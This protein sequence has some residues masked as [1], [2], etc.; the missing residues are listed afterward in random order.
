MVS[1]TLYLAPQTGHHEPPS[2]GQ[3]SQESHHITGSAIT[4]LDQQPPATGDGPEE[5]FVV[6]KFMVIQF[7]VA[8]FVVI[9]FRVA[10][11]V[12]IKLVVAKFMVINFNVEKFMISK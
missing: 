11:F 12:V 8:K 1:R 6:A 2:P 9:K 4:V 5:T 7:R 3:W 10:K